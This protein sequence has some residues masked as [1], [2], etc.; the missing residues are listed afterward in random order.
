MASL[1]PGPGATQAQAGRRRR[2][3]AGR[4][5]PLRAGGPGARGASACFGLNRFSIDPSLRARRRART[6]PRAS[7]WASASRPTSTSLY[8]HGPAR[9]RGAAASVEYT[10]S[11]RFSLLLTPRRARRL[12]F[13]LR[14]R[15]VAL[16]RAGVARRRSWPRTAP[17][18]SA[19]AADRRLRAHRGAAARAGAARAATS[20][21]SRASRSTPE[22]RAARRSSCSTP[23]ASTRTCVVETTPRPGGRGRRVPSGPGAAAG[24]RCAWRATACSCRRRSRRTARGCAPR[25]PLWPARLEQAARDVAPGPGRARLPRGARRA[26]APSRRRAAP[27]P[28]SR[29]RR[30]ARARRTAAR[31]RSARRSWPRS[32]AAMPPAPGEAFRRAQSQARGRAHARRPGRPRLLARR[33]DA[34]RGLRP[35]HGAMGLAFRVAPGPLRGRG[36]A[37]RERE[38]G[39]VRRVARRSCARAGSSRTR[40][41]RRRERL[42]EDCAAAGHRDAH[43]TPSRGAARAA[44]GRSSTTWRPGPRAVVASVRVEGDGADGLEAA[45]EHACRASRSSGRDAGGGRA[46]A[47][48]APWRSAATRTPAWRPRCRRAAAACPSSSA[49]APGPRT[50]V[51]SLRVR[52]ARSRCPRTSAPRELR[53]ARGRALP[54]A[55]PGPRPGR[56]ARRL[57]QRRLPRRPRWR[58]R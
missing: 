43:V 33:G 41:R 48:R 9:Q 23:P 54:R 17:A 11:D 57:P 26:R 25:E 8:S 38:P 35:A 51:T 12:G 19:T 21:S 52:D 34:W 37:R 5:P 28:C 27:T 6:P 50:R 40:S 14:L 32:S 3:H 24:A 55:R 47:A 49:S 2:G 36:A 46:R 58:P 7:P 18:A 4:R 39:C 31:R 1:R 45:L 42:E 44:P 56:R 53:T 22:R 10:L 15:A 29:S 16:M 20:R 30:P 13:D